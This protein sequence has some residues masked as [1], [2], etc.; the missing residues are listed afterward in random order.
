MKYWYTPNISIAAKFTA[1]ADPKAKGEIA[2]GLIQVNPWTKPLP[3]PPPNF[4]LKP[5]QVP[6]V[7][8]ALER[9]RSYLRLDP[10]L[11]KTIVAATIA[12]ATGAKTVYV[13]PPFLALNVLHEFSI[14]APKLK[15]THYLAYRVAP[16]P[17]N[18]DVLVLPDTF[19]EQAYLYVKEFA[20]IEASRESLLVVDEAHR[21]KNADAKRTRYLLGGIVKK[22]REKGKKYNG[23][24]SFFDRRV[25]MSGTPMPNRPMELFKLL[26]IEAPETIDF[27]NYFEFGRHYCAGYQDSYG[28]WDFSGASNMRELSQKTVYPTGPFMY[29]LKKDQL[30]LPPKL[31]QVFLLYDNM[32]PELKT[33]DDSI[34]KS[35]GDQTQETL[36]NELLGA[37]NGELHIATY[38]RLLGAEKA[39]AAI[40]FLKSILDDSNESVIVF[41][42]HVD[43]IQA[44]E[45]ELSK[46]RPYVI[47]GK[48]KVADRHG[49]VKDFQ[50]DKSRRLIIGNY[51]AMGVGFTLT[52]AT[53]VVFVE[54]DWV[55]GVNDQA[56]DRVHRIGQEKTVLVQYMA[57][58][59]SIDE[60]VISALLNKR[61]SINHL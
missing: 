10:G 12:K 41:A 61:K 36:I 28:A 33:F 5:Y 1:Y 59:G 34:R 30:E 9:D 40:P 15:T 24:Y 35:L 46:Y 19:L 23:L 53:R 50:A 60:K 54:F 55:P 49:L 48:T 8:F 2:K 26:S 17:K 38:R 56:S 13:T 20:Q 29:R 47:S 43:V 37:D 39:K 4:Q 21:F 32:A 57:F 22:P 3:E 58:A 16:D 11:G 27:R 18:A 51:V 31:E 45:N 44:L 42:Y 14:W 7:L 25:Y 6:A 52:K